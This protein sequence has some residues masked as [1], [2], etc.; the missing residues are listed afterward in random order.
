MEKTKKKNENYLK[1]IKEILDVF[2]KNEIK[3]NEMG[4][5][6]DNLKIAVTASIID[7]ILKHKDK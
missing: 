4:E 6:L 2:K 3:P 7:V 1:V 5:I